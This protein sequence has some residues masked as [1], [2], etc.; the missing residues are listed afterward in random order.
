[1]KKYDVALEKYNQLDTI[2]TNFNNYIKITGIMAFS[3]WLFYI[4]F[5]ILGKGFLRN[6]LGPFLLGVFVTTFTLFFMIGWAKD[7]VVKRFKKKNDDLFK[8]PKRDINLFIKM[9]NNGYDVE[10]IEKEINTII[11]NHK[12]D[13]KKLSNEFFKYTMTDTFKKKVLEY[14]KY[15]ELETHYNVEV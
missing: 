13:D 9:K 5:I 10:S 6:D 15:C 8:Y 1:M 14:S 7:I 11:Q 2:E 4:T 12:L 3:I